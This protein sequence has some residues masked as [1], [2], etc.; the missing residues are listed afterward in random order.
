MTSDFTLALFFTRN[1]SLQDWLDSGLFER[2]K[3]LYE[4][5]LNKGYIKK[6]YWFTY[7]SQD[8]QIAQSLISQGRL[9]PAI[10]ICPMPVLFQSHKIFIN[11]Y[12]FLLPLIW[13]RLFRKID[14]LKTNQMDGSWSALI[15]NFTFNKPL[16]LRTGF[17]LS[18]LSGN[19]P[20]ICFLKRKLILWIEKISYRYC[21][22]ATVTSAH[23]KAYVI[24][25]YNISPVNCHV[26]GNGIDTQL[27][28]PMG[29]N[30]KNKRLLFVGR[31]HQEKNLFS[32]IEACGILSIGL[33]IY[34]D[35]PLK[36]D[37]YRFAAEAS[38]D[39]NFKGTVANTELARIYNTYRFYI[40]PSFHEGMPKTLLEAMASGCLCIGTD[41]NGI[42]EVIDDGFNGILSKGTDSQSLVIAIRRAMSADTQALSNNAIAFIRE[43]YAFSSIIEKE[44]QILL[45]LAQ[46]AG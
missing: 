19:N 11:L 5:L 34:G 33:D 1:I 23:N 28:S 2:E 29:F 20:A 24:Q 43:H 17:T 4:A 3:F 32:L 45:Q 40:L 31:L 7:G 42:N 10:E 22:A 39:V 35:G 13:Y 37:L 8:K 36:N 41:V 46:N 44:R 26:V 9:H 15:A 25:H 38:V 18:Q 30:R 27:F 16:L 21:D 12:S 14:V 6:I